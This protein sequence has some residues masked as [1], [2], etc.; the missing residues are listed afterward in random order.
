[1]KKL[2]GSS[3]KPIEPPAMIVMP[4]QSQALPRNVNSNLYRRMRW[5]I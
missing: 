3:Y 1:M 2:S 5:D 4:T